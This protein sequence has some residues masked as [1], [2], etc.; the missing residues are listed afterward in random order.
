ML[1]TVGPNLCPIVNFSI[2]WPLQYMISNLVRSTEGIPLSILVLWEMQVQV[3]FKNY[4]DKMK[5]VFGQKN[6]LQLIVHV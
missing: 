6:T 4:V 5:W 2:P 3:H 1:P